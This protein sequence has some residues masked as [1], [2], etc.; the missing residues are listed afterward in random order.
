M[1]TNASARADQKDV[2]A[3]QKKVQ[4]SFRDLYVNKINNERSDNDSVSTLSYASNSGHLT[5]TIKSHPLRKAL[6]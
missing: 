6:T 5:P 2:Y 4:N 3:Q 1:V